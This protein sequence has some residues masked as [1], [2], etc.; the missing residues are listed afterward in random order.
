[1]IIGYLMASTLVYAVIV[2]TASLTDGMIVE[3]VSRHLLQKW[4]DTCA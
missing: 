3:R 4:S 1:M 2:R